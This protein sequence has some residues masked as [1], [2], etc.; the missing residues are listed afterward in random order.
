MK[1]RC[2]F[3]CI[4]GLDASGKTTQTRRLVANLRLKGFD[5]VYTTE[6]SSGEFG[7]FIR[8][9]VLQRIGRVPVVVE[10]LLFAADRVDHV[11]QEIKPALQKGRIVVSDRYVF[12]S[13]AYQGAAGL[14][15]NWIEEINKLAL[16]PDLAIYIDV[17]LG[18]VM[19]RMERM[20]RRQSVM[21]QLDI[22]E[23]VRQVY[24]QLVQDGR[25]F[26]VD[27]NR[28]ANVVSADIYKMVLDKLASS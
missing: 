2:L 22:Q 27:G 23:K 14:D 1:K 24:M 18:V 17:P 28:P 15:L 19:K 11:E 20:R 10:A 5:A 16:Q 7:S 13:L 12:S 9:N 21:E 25:L 3:I 6:P 4:E 26:P 8:S